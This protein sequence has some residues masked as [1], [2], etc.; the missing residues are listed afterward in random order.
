MPIRKGAG[1]GSLAE[2]EKADIFES[3]SESSKKVG[4]LEK[5]KT[6]DLTSEEPGFYGVIAEGQKGYVKSSELV[7]AIDELPAAKDAEFAARAKAASDAMDAAGH[8]AGKA[9][10][11]AGTAP[12]GSGGALPDWFR[13]LQY[14]LSMVTTWAK[15]EDDAQQVLDDYMTF[16]MEAWHGDVPPSVKYP[17]PATRGAARSTSPAPPR[18][19]STASG[20]SAAASTTRASRTPTGAP[21]PA[22]A[23]S[24]TRCATWATPRRSGSRR[25]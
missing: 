21:R 4:T 15:E 11:G 22:R 12:A 6:V 17:L 14:K 23:R 1:H 16:Y 8:A 7:T 10:R 20:S 2:A 3:P 24:S 13:Q 19:A 5:G 25:S 9:L 18:A